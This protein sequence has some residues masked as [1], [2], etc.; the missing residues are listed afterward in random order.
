MSQREHNEIVDGM[1]IGLW[2]RAVDNRERSGKGPKTI[3]TKVV[4]AE[5]EAARKAAADLTKLYEHVNGKSLDELLLSANRKFKDAHGFGW[6]LAEQATQEPDFRMEYYV[7]IKVPY[8]LIMFTKGGKELTWEGAESDSPGKPLGPTGFG[9]HEK[10]RRNAIE[11]DL[12]INPSFH[13]GEHVRVAGGAHGSKSRAWTGR[14]IWVG[15]PGSRR[16]TKV[17][18][19]D[20]EPHVGSSGA[21]VEASEVRRINPDEEDVDINPVGRFTEKGER[22]YQDIKAGYEAQGEPRAAEIAART[23][24]ARSRETPG[25]LRVGLGRPPGVPNRSRR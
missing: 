7:G 6:A 12:G 5:Q 9:R 25:L 15:E 4:E 20:D 22:M 16:A 3:S 23:V 17:Q 21:W 8:F 11:D 24:Y 2:T 13:V 14:I 18:V 10:V 19:E 1:T